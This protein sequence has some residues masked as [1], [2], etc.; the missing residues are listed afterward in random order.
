MRAR[1]SGGRNLY[2]ANSALKRIGDERE[3]FL[4]AASDGVDNCPAAGA[5]ADS[6]TLAH[7]RELGMEPE[8][9]LAHADC[10]TLFQKSGDAIYTG[11]TGANVSDIMM[12]IRD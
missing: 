2:L 3:L 7:L 12:Y 10:L 1:G 4:S 6:V 8:E 11:S 9:Y 5:L